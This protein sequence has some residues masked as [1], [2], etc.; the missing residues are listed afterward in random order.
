MSLDDDSMLLEFQLAQ[1]FAA[2]P[3][4]ST[5][6]PESYSGGETEITFGA[7]V[8]LAAPEQTS[9]ETQLVNVVNNMEI[10]EASLGSTTAGVTAWSQPLSTWL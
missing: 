3:R 5:A 1:V 6:H 9:D 2:P 10:D 8:R 4:G 7:S